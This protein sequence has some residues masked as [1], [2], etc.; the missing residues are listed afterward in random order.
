MSPRLVLTRNELNGTRSGSYLLSHHHLNRR[1]PSEKME[2]RFLR[3]PTGSRRARSKSKS[4]IGSVGDQSGVGQ[5]VLPHKGSTPA[6]QTDTSASP[7]SSSLS[8]RDQE[9]N[10]MQATFFWMRYLIT[11]FAQH[12]SCFPFRPVPICFP[13]KRA[14]RPPEILRS[15]R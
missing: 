1:R 9:S 13:Q 10:G 8:P 4:E 3:L 7:S 14:K 2:S 15:H 12:R 5:S 6:L 11:F